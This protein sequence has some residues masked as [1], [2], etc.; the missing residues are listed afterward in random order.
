MPAPEKTRIVFI[1]YLVK[2]KKHP[3]INLDAS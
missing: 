3:E 1:T 2:I